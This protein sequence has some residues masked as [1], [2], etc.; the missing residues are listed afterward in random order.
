MINQRL[1]RSQERLNDREAEVLAL[2]EKPFDTDLMRA[3][4]LSLRYTLAARLGP[5][6][7]LPILL[8]MEHYFPLSHRQVLKKRVEVYRKLGHP[9]LAQAEQDL[10]FFTKWN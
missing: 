9:N 6:A 4:R 5:E 1:S 10:N 7:L 2:L 3:E 8:E